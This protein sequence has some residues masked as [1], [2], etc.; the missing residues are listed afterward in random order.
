MTGMHGA[1]RHA[2]AAVLSGGVL[3]GGFG[4]WPGAP[5][6]TAAAAPGDTD[7]AVMLVVDTSG[8]MA[9]QPLVQ[10]KA[11]LLATI[12]GLDAADRAG[13]RSFDG[14]C[15]DGGDLRVA[16]GVDNR[17]QLRAAVNA[18]QAG[19]GTPTPAALRAA[20]ADFPADAASKIL[21]LVSDGASTCGDPCPVAAELKATLGI[22]FQAFTVGFKAPAQAAVELACIASVTGGRYVS[23]TDT[24]SLR[25]ALDEAATGGIP[26]AQ[27]FGSGC[28]GAA[29][30]SSSMWGKP[31]NTA[32]GSETLRVTDATL[33][34]PG[35][36]CDFTR[37]YNS[38]DPRTGPLGQGWTH[39]LTSGLLLDEPGAVTYRGPEGQ[40]SRFFLSPGGGYAAAPGVSATLAAVSGGGWQLTYRDRRVM[41]FD[42]AGRLTTAR[43]R[44]GT[45]LDLAYT[46]GRLSS[47]TGAGGR[48]LTL[49]YDAAGLLSRVTLP[50]GRYV[51]Y[52]YTSG[53]L[54]RARDLR[55]QFTTYA[56][57]SS[58]R[59]SRITDP[60]GREV[61]NVY[62]AVTGRV[63][64]Q[65]DAR[66]FTTTFGWDEATDVATITRPDGAVWVEDYAGNL[67]RSRTDPLGNVETFGYD[68]QVNLTSVTDELG[69][70]TSMTYD[71]AGNMLSR[72]SP[73]VPGV[74]AGYTQ[75]WTYDAFDD[76]TSATDGRGLTTSMTYTPTGLPVTVTDAAG[77][78]T[79]YTHD[80]RGQVT[81]VVDARGGA[82]SM[83]Y[84]AEGDLVAV[85]SP[86]GGRATFEHD[87]VGRVTAVV[88][89]TGNAAGGVASAH[90]T[91]YSYDDGDLLLSST[92]AAGAVTRFG[93]DAAGQRTTVTD[94]VGR[95]TTTGYDAA[96]NVTSTTDA[97]GAVWSTEYDSV[98]RVTA[99]V[100]PAGRTMFG[101]DAVG[102]PVSE[103]TPRGN[104]A[105]ADPARFRWQ[106]AFDAAGNRTST[107][108]PL[109]AVTRFTHDGLDRVISVT[110][111]RGSTTS[112]EYDA[113]G[114]VTAAVDAEGNGTVTRFDS[115]NRV[116]EV[117]DPRE[118]SWVSR[119]EYLPTG[120]RSAVVSADGSRWAW[121]YDAAGRMVAAVEPRGTAVGAVA[122]DF[123]TTYA[124]DVADQLTR[125]VDPLG[126]STSHSYDV[127]GRRVSTTDPR[128][129]VTTWTHGAD[130]SL[131][132][133]RGPVGTG[134]TT[135]GYDAAA[136]LVTRRDA[137]D[138]VTSFGYDGARRMTSM[139]LPDGRVWRYSY[140]AAGN[141]T[142]VETPTGTGTPDVAGDG[143]IT[144]VHDELGRRTGLDYSDATPDVSWTYDA[145][146]NR[147]GMS[148]G[149]GTTAY[150]YD[151]ANR[152]TSITASGDALTFGYD[153]AGNVTGRGYPDGTR[154]S[155][156]YDGVGRLSG[157][158]RTVSGAV[159]GLL[160]PLVRYSYDPAGRPS[161]ALL[162]NGVGHSWSYDRAG[163]QTGITTTQP[164]P[165]GSAGQVVSGVSATLDPAG[166]PVRLTTS[167]PGLDDT[168]WGAGPPTVSED[169]Y[170]YDLAGR[171]TQQCRGLAAGEV[172]DSSLVG[173]TG[174]A[175][176]PVGN[177]VRE[178]FVGVAGP[179]ASRSFSYDAADRMTARTW[180]GVRTSVTHDAS[181]NV[182]RDAA[183][184]GFTWDLG[185]RLT[186]VTAGGQTLTY[187]YDGDG[188]QTRNGSSTVVWD[189]TFGV[190]Q[191]VA[192]RSGTGG[193]QAWQREWV[194]GLPGTGPVSVTTP[195]G[196]PGA[197][198]VTG[199][200]HPG[201]A[202][203][204]VAVSG[205][206][207]VPAGVAD[208]DLFGDGRW[209]PVF[210][211]EGQ[212]NW[213][214]ES[215]LNATGSETLAVQG[216]VGGFGEL[217]D[218][219]TSGNS[220]GTGGLVHLRA[221]TMDPTTSRFL[222]A[223]P[224][225]PPI[226]DPYITAYAYA[227]NRPGVLADP[228]GLCSIGSWWSDQVSA[229][230]RRPGNA[231]ATED[232][233]VI[234]PQVYRDMVRNT[235]DAIIGGL[236][237]INDAVTFGTRPSIRDL[238]G[239]TYNSNAYN[240]VYGIAG[241][242]AA[243]TPTPTGKGNAVRAV[244]P[245][246]RFAVDGAGT[247]VDR[248]ATYTTR[249]GP[250]NPGP[251]ADDVANTFRSGTY[252]AVQAGSTTTL[253][254]V[255]NGSRE[256]GSFWTRMPPGGP[257]QSIIDSAL[258]PAWGNNAT[259]WVQIRVPAGTTLYEGSTA[260]QGGLVGGGSQ[261]IVPHVDPTWIVGRGV[262]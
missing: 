245:G 254:R 12:D 143:T 59:L 152:V 37:T 13:L 51:E 191:P 237:G 195:G 52:G 168:G 145:V 194:H 216:V 223:D 193:A 60:L 234:G 130:G 25:E 256:L 224:L 170:V 225:T 96:G 78:V 128:G 203:S 186:S 134:T 238:T 91:R 250:M 235:D 241:I 101:Y 169:G 242:G 1:L 239:C 50:D 66:G 127:V 100:T 157:I 227:D 65:T 110:D 162:G 19:G 258:T 147:T 135:Y 159:A 138:R 80:V 55:G 64:S 98:G 247:V 213:E 140:D 24:A 106:H 180:A 99:S 175:Y 68:G 178:S 111:A 222:G 30:S 166:N 173:S 199:W 9:G 118:A 116:S 149:T 188:V 233:T 6:V 16:P 172:C 249:Y 81:R 120:E 61:S 85:V 139:T 20:A 125:V 21:V 46:G 119:F 34:G 251:L 93:Y 109:G 47:V 190:A 40:Q 126:N 113:N 32:T 108:D 177:R 117:V 131:A 204:P 89:P 212:V 35:V 257:V 141:R 95:T 137:L 261:V 123:T 163:R 92:D 29:R 158:D 105:G 121:E 23:A 17:E 179:A 124:Y 73:P 14:G 231:C 94:P 184:R 155:Y 219:G 90:T 153:A 228:T 53:R 151:R 201:W 244:G 8:S 240:W 160:G 187:G 71:A 185:N 22:N 82:T 70:V 232:R 243:F 156:A 196:Y 69:R 26:G 44:T 214:T 174:Y 150:T 56:Y 79:R 260:A 165:A 197:P 112:T 114:N 220:V 262:F 181:G 176:D 154:L 167:R 205:D 198:A 133:V 72:T 189:P 48:S 226:S 253:Y 54:T 15:V 104:V 136:N 236:D 76:M 103:V 45:G 75:R 36:P 171:V 97:T 206:G 209:R 221:R 77:A 164:G 122:G 63:S 252:S 18:L 218:P 2:V 102:N 58:G 115:V 200:V 215:G 87:V 246:A 74:P 255:H 88:S 57:D 11:A 3:L 208:F 86:V 83:S 129:A 39:S 192:Q 5:V 161:S 259:S 67:L 146:G 107:R 4:A 230:N 33:P 148:D 211:G 142:A 7:R 27:T 217:S 38:A 210:A 144:A 132:A 41:T 182:T 49:T 43:D 28:D 84:D 42:A 31:V 10:A 202:G 207:G 229:L 248:L 183:G 62:D